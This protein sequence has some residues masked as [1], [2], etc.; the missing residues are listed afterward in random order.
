VFLT[1]HGSF[2]PFEDVYSTKRYEKEPSGFRNAPFF[3]IL[4]CQRCFRVLKQRVVNYTRLFCCRLQA[5]VQQNAM[6]KD[7][8]GFRNTPCFYILKCQRF[9]SILNTADLCRLETVIQ[10]NTMK[11]SLTYQISQTLTLSNH[12]TV[13]GKE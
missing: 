6:K 11:K 1:T 12:F 3:D 5:L 2:V 13:K 10:Q 4:K 7:P 9:V 8:S